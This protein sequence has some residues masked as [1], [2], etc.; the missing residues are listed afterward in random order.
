MFVIHSE[1]PGTADALGRYTCRKQRVVCTCK[2]EHLAPVGGALFSAR[3]HARRRRS[4]ASLSNETSVPLRMRSKALH[5]EELGQEGHRPASSTMI[6]CFG[7]YRYGAASV[8]GV[9]SDCV[10]RYSERQSSG[11][12]SSREDSTPREYCAHRGTHLAGACHRHREHTECEFAL[13]Q[14]LVYG[15][16]FSSTRGTSPGCM[17]CKLQGQP[18][19]FD[20]IRLVQCTLVHSLLQDSEPALQR[21]I[22]AAGTS[23]TSLAHG[24]IFKTS[25]PCLLRA[26]ARIQGTCADRTHVTMLAVSARAKLRHVRLGLG[27]MP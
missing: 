7:V 12:N 26:K 20:F 19:A 16:F 5:L 4:R 15:R 13:L 21:S 8:S 11:E 24:Q 18:Q 1:S 9:P 6:P 23:T 27:N 17:V 22:R 25:T 14:I 2:T 3:G 10:L